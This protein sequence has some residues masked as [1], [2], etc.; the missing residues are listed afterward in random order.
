L[1]KNY[2]IDQSIIYTYATAI[3]PDEHWDG[4]FIQ[5]TFPGP[6]NTTL[7]LTTETMIIP[8]TYP[9]GPCQGEQCFGTLV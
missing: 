2:R 3:P 5:V 9:V 1:L 8:N 4:V 7:I 6:E